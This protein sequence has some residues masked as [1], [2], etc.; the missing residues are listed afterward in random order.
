MELVDGGNQRRI[1][2][3]DKL[4]KLISEYRKDISFIGSYM[5]KGSDS[6]ADVVMSCSGPMEAFF[7]LRM[8]DD[9]ATLKNINDMQIKE[10]R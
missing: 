1:E 7:L 5:V 6:Q 4:D 9:Q 10:Q 2:F 3:H 8:V